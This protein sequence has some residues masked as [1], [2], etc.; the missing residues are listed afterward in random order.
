MSDG[1]RHARPASRNAGKPA[2][3]C[4]HAGYGRPIPITLLQACSKING[5][6]GSCALA[7][8][9]LVG[10]VELLRDPTLTR[11]ETTCV[12][13]P[14]A[15]VPAQYPIPTGDHTRPRFSWGL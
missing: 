10:W 11:A 1:S 3:R 4:T 13:S 14:T 8:S 2:C 5:V 7:A 12:P 9:G 15:G 6:V